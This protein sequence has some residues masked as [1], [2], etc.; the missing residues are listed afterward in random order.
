MEAGISQEASAS[1]PRQR[2][3]AQREQRQLP[4]VG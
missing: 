1:Q 4:R 2:E 3:K